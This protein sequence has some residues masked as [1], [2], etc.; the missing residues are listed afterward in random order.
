M[1]QQLALAVD[2]G[3]ITQE[4]ADQRIEECRVTSQRLMDDPTVGTQVAQ[5]ADRLVLLGLG[6]ATV[7][8]T[9]L[10][11]R[12]VMRRVVA[13]ETLAE[14][15]TAEGATVEAVLDDFTQHATTL[16]NRGVER[17]TMTRAE[18]DTRLVELTAAAAT[19][20]NEPVDVEALR[21]LRRR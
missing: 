14:I 21:E 1:A 10:P 5:Q 8:A 17:G 16:L 19:Q 3:V 20:V 15:A 6:H 2:E 4:F 7:E 12:E 13:G 18:A 9:G 11:R